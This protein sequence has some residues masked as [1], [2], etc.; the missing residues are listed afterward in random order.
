MAAVSN[1]DAILKAAIRAI[2]LSKL[3]IEHNV[4]RFKPAFSAPS[5]TELQG[6]LR[7]ETNQLRN[8]CKFA[9][10]LPTVSESLLFE[11]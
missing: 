11:L 4:S 8:L 2:I 1:R 7:H 6:L 10:S 3:F 5:C 9:V